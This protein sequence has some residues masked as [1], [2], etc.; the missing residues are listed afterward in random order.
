MEAGLHIEL[1]DGTVGWALTQQIESDLEIDALNEVEAPA[2]PT[3]LPTEAS[4]EAPTEI[5][6]TPTPEGTPT[7]EIKYEA[8]VQNG[9]RGWFQMG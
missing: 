3:A 6:E 1:A 5:A 2:T 4:T 7:P 9:P 8:P